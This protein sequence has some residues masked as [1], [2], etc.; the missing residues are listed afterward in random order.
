MLAD[1]EGD[2]DF[3]IIRAPD[4]T[5]VLEARA[6]GLGGGMD[7]PDVWGGELPDMPLFCERGHSLFERDSCREGPDWGSLSLERDLLGG[8]VDGLGRHSGV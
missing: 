5:F 1:F 2:P 7:P 3:M 8:I 4:S 6:P